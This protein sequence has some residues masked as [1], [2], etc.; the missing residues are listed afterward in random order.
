MIRKDLPLDDGFIAVDHEYADGKR[1]RHHVIQT[2][3]EEYIA[4]L[5]KAYAEGTNTPYMPVKLYSHPFVE[6]LWEYK[7]KKK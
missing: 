2:T 1:T 4:Q 7:P 6:L 3:L 5:E